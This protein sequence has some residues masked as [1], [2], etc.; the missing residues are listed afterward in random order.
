MIIVIVTAI[1]SVI[2]ISSRKISKRSPA[3]QTT[4]R[5]L[6]HINMQSLSHNINT[7]MNVAYESIHGILQ[8]SH[9]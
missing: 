7:E 1:F 6:E 3:E 4:D 2:V 5:H 9:Q 8:D